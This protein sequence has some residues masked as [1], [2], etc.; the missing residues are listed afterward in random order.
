MEG[1]FSR[2]S[3]MG[4][5]FWI[6]Y[7]FQLINWDQYFLNLNT[8]SK[9]VYVI[10]PFPIHCGDCSV[11]SKQPCDFSFFSSSFSPFLLHFFPSSSFLRWNWFLTLN[12]NPREENPLVMYLLMAVKIR[13]RNRQERRKMADKYIWKQLTKEQIKNAFWAK[14]KQTNKRGS[15]LKNITSN[16]LSAFTESASPDLGNCL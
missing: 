11:S 2:Q 12:I 4:L 8:D 1:S 10:R 16:L 15:P 13:T 9:P 3:N 7:V 6:F 14:T 5:N